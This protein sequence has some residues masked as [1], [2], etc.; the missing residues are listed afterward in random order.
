MKVINY[1]ATFTTMTNRVE[2]LSPSTLLACFISRFKREI[3]RDV[4]P[5]RPDSINE[6]VTLAK[7]FEE[8]YFPTSKSSSQ[9]S[10]LTPN[11]NLLVNAG[12]HG[13][14]LAFLAKPLPTPAMPFETRTPSSLPTP[15]HAP[16]SYKKK[17]NQ[18]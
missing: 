4:I 14:I 16:H 15:N 17:K 8:K 5:W 3:H 12:K 9:R 18:F 2:G 10:S 6:A 7:L 11:I 13:T 1:Y